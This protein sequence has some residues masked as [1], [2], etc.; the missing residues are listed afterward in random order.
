MRVGAPFCS[1]DFREITKNTSIGDLQLRKGENL[2]IALNLNHFKES[3]FEKALKF[4]RNRFLDPT[5][6]YCR[7]HNAAFGHGARA[8]IGKSMAETNIK[9][10]V[11]RMLEHFD[12]EYLRDVQGFSD[13]IN[14]LPFYT[15]QNVTLRLRLRK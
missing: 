3:E 11:L 1:T 7:Q 8:C 12:F 14:I 9:I 2:L 6:R 5:K 13:Q 10:I 4:D 15:L